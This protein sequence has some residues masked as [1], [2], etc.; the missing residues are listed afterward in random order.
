MAFYAFS[1]S[2]LAAS[3]LLILSAAT[4]VF[5]SIRFW[6][7][8]QKAS[9]QYRVFWLF[10]RLFFLGIIVTSTLDF[11]GLGKPDIWQLCI[12]AITALLGFSLAFH[13]TFA[14]GWRDAHGEA[15]SLQTEGWYSWSR[16]PVYVLTIIGMVGVGMVVHSAY[17]YVLLLLWA[18]MYI[19][20]PLLE[21]PWL[22][23]CY[24][25]AFRDYKTRVNRFFGRRTS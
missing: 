5:P 15:N 3:V 9:W 7:P 17:S 13:A 20:A 25:D 6:P 1:F 18:V 11:A 21:E 2:A 8:P 16:N 19:I 4:L 22:E 10:F 24:G 14:L 12:G 23:Q